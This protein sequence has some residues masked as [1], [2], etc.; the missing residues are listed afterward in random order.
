MATRTAATTE[1]TPLSASSLLQSALERRQELIASLHAEDT[2]C[3]RLFHGAVEGRPG[4][5]IDRYG[6][7]LLVQTWRDPLEDGE[8]ETFRT[9]AEEALQTGLT[10][11]WNH[12]ERGQGRRP[13]SH[14]HAV[15]PMSVTCRELGLEYDARPRHRGRDPLLFLDFRAARRRILARCRGRSV[16]NLFAY[17]CG[18]G[19]CA[20]AGGA[21][22]VLNVDFA[23]S[24][25]KVGESNA[26]RNGL[27]ASFSTLKEDVIPVIRQ[28][29]G[30]G[31]RWR[32]KRP[33]FTPL[34]A[35][36]W[37]VVVLDPPRWAKGRFG[38]VDV[39]GD[40][41]SLLKPSLLS[42]GPGGFVLATN[43][44][45]SVDLSSWLDSVRRCGDKAGRPVVD[46]EVIE[47]E[48]DWPTRDGRPPLKMAWLQ[49]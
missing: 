2:D 37:D 13:F 19:V 34:D 6:P 8:L 27:T 1:T 12:R 35:R 17:T 32:G 20:A 14:F 48:G 29:S 49:V 10:T 42:T 3:Y 30:L 44:V 40:Y 5:T 4:V 11:V 33:R 22:E 39:V 24:A 36:T 25:L 7:I 41:A 9:E 15:E 21:R 23:E 28:F 43:N 38:A 47:P 16:L 46:I 45:A 18:I 26:S 31:V